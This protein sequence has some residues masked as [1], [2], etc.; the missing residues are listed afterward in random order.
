MVSAAKIQ[1]SIIMLFRVSFWLE[2]VIDSMNVCF[3][4]WL[5]VGIRPIVFLW[6]LK[7]G[8]ANVDR[9]AA[10]SKL[11]L[12]MFFSIGDIDR[13]TIYLQLYYPELCLYAHQ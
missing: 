12:T 13:E 8:K 3:E 7:E 2:R 10:K 11:A 5:V 9:A 6:D 4:G 1:F